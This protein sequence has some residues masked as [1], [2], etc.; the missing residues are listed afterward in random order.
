MVMGSYGLVLLL[1]LVRAGA[2]ELEDV[3]AVT[4]GSAG[5]EMEEVEVEEVVEEV[6]V[7]DSAAYKMSPLEGAA[8]ELR[9]DRVRG[10]EQLHLVAR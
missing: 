9:L 6:V 8:L 10:E 2:G 7:L 5:E 3:E 1:L 4:E